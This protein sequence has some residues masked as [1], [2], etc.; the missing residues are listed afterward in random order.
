MAV[1]PMV[2]LESDFG[3]R[4]PVNDFNPPTEPLEILA[5]V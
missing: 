1:L 2:A 3:T 5:G 4:A